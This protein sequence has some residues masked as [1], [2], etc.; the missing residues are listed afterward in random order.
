[1]KVLIITLL[2]ILN[3][4]ALTDNE[5]KHLLL[6]TGFDVQQSDINKLLELDRKQAFQYIISKHDQ[7]KS[8]EIPDWL[9][10]YRDLFWGMRELNQGNLSKSEVAKLVRDAKAYYLRVKDFI[11]ENKNFNFDV[12]N[13]R[14][15]LREIRK[16]N[17]MNLFALQVDWYE[18]MINTQ[19]PL[20]EKMTIFWHNHFVSSLKKV[21]RADWMYQQISLLRSQSL[22]N[23]AYLLEHITIDP[24]MLKYLDG[25]KNNA[26]SPNENYARE[27][28]ELFT[29]GQGNYTEKD[30][31]EVA[32]AL[33]G[34]K[35]NQQTGTFRFAKRKHDYGVKTILGTTGNFGYKDVIRILI[36][37]YQTAIFITNKIWKEFISFNPNKDVVEKW[38]KKF[39]DSN[40]DIKVLLQEVL[41]SDEFYADVNRGALIK[42][43][44]EYTIG[45]LRQFKLSFRDWTALTRFNKNLGQSLYD[46]PNVK[47][48]AGGKSWITT[49]TLLDRQQFV[50]K[51][52]NYQQNENI[53]GDKSDLASWF[54][55]LEGKD[56][57]AKARS[58][59][60]AIDDKEP[61]L[62]RNNIIRVL[63]DIML[64]PHYQ[65]K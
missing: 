61:I 60:L 46:P 57:M 28:M 56:K 52:I 44:V 16:L 47:G 18:K 43:P 48:W 65:L 5:A 49:S 42:S 64:K 41:T 45:I 40:Y 7:Y 14:K 29:L 3:S 53:M 22:G 23:F 37:H 13:H 36:S 30:I 59:L 21:K 19:S 12:K 32:R 54:K 9:K 39:R 55:S 17:R 27:V 6:R 26:D 62:R 1:M 34:L 31:K 8:Y 10:G 2:F 63:K 20:T 38:A 33:T 51:F 24:A 58:I 35:I 4:F 15:L 11:P 25:V 50:R